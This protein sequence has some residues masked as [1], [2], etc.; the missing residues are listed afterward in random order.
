MIADND[1]NIIYTNKSVIHVLGEAEA[2]VRKVL[3]N[4]NVNN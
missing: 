1:R 4:F 3:P 2:D